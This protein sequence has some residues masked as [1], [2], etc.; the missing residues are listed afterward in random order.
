[1]GLRQGCE[2]VLIPVLF[3]KF[4]VCFDPVTIGTPNYAQFYFS[5]HRFE[6]LT[7]GYCKIFVSNMVE[8]QSSRVG[9]IP[10][11]ETP[12][13]QFVRGQPDTNFGRCR[14]S[15]LGVIRPSLVN[16]VGALFIR[17]HSGHFFSSMGRFFL[18]VHLSSG[19]ILPHL[20]GAFVPFSFVFRLAVGGS[21]FFVC[22]SVFYHV[23]KHYVTCGGVK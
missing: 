18:R 19:S 7:L 4:P 22:H 23:L 3:T 13:R 6:D 8:V 20:L 21:F 9:V 14:S 15:S 10:A 2:N 11:V 1:M 12:L 17:R 16:F 5:L